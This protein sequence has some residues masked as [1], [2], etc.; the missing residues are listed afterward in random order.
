MTRL[1]DQSSI[2]RAYEVGATDFIIKP[3][4]WVI[5]QKRLRYM[6]RAKAAFKNLTESEARNR[7]LLKAIPD[8]MLTLDAN[9]IILDV[10]EGPN[11]NGFL[12]EG[13]QAG[14]SVADLFPENISNQFLINISRVLRMETGHNFEYSLSIDRKLGSFECRC[15]ISSPNEVLALIRDITDRK[16]AE[17]KIHFL[18]HYDGL[19]SLPNKFLFQELLEEAIGHAEQNNELLALILLNIDRFQQVN[20]AFGHESGDKLIKAVSDRL[21]AFIRCSDPIL[22]NESEKVEAPI[23]RFGGDE[24][25]ILVFHLPNEEAVSRV[26]QRLHD[27]LSAPF[28]IDDRE[29]FITASIGVSLFPADGL[30]AGALLKNAGAAM[31]YA[32][33]LGRSQSHFFAPFMKT[34]YESSLSLESEMRKAIA[35][36][37][38]VLYYQ[39]K[40]TIADGLLSGVEALIRWQHPTKGLLFPGEFIP[41]AEDSELI[42]PI[43]EWVLKTACSQFYS[44]KNEGIG[45]IPIAVNLSQT[46]FKQKYLLQTITRILSS[47]GMD[48]RFLELEITESAIMQ[49]ER[50]AGT[51]L[52]GLKA[53]G[54]KLSID[55]FGTGYSSLSALKRFTLDCLKIDRSFIMDLNLDRDDR[56]LVSAI[57]AMAHSLG[58]RVIAEGVETEEQLAFLRDQQCDM[59]QGYFISR[60]IPAQQL[61]QLLSERS[62]LAIAEN[63]NYQMFPTEMSTKAPML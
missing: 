49:N 43:G 12:P 32:K 5:I 34:H 27:A 61:S 55:D 35:N 39:P 62:Q 24:F 2:D 30:D 15:A 22:R 45:T 20:D 4:N 48:S 60:P 16:Q 37:E 56:A 6:L 46:Q 40:I 54:I 23:A 36:N 50:E 41:L 19:T 25:T 38:F 51:M 53:L 47:M 63:L 31:H 11:L 33:T 26:A 52:R 14:K 28:A 1:D 29:I 18:A 9:G 13:F 8:M 17:A 21:R 59:A 58:L 57:I 44:W 7:A 42:I 3:V 10:K